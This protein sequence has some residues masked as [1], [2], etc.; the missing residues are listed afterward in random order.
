MNARSYNLFPGAERFYN[1]EMQAWSAAENSL[2]ALVSRDGARTAFPSKHHGNLFFS[3]MDYAA[4]LTREIADSVIAGGAP[5]TV[6]GAA[7]EGS[8]SVEVAQ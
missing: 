4:K 1:P 7:V 2:H 6:A 8:V 3:T 5:T